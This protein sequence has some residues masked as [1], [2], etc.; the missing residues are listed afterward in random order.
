MNVQQL[1]VQCRRVCAW[2]FYPAGGLV[3]G[4]V[5]LAQKLALE[6]FETE[7]LACANKMSNTQIGW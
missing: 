2:C 6:L 3:T 1:D 7:A 4:D 5:M